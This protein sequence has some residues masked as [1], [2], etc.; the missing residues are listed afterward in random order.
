MRRACRSSSTVHALAAPERSAAHGSDRSRISFGRPV[1]AGTGIPTAVLAERF[2]AGDQPPDWRKTTVQA[3][4]RSGTRS[5]AKSTSRPLEPVT[6]FVDESLDSL[7]VVAALPRR[8][9]DRPT[10][11]RTF[12][13]VLRR[14]LARRS[15]PQRLGRP[16]AR[17]TYPLPPARQPR[18][19]SR[20]GAGHL[21]SRAE[22]HR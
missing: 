5:A 1:I 17:Q 13:R 21:C 2:K 19:A 11:H 15:R 12:P 6:F 22:C 9:G 10:S 3:K 8:R 16:D 18:P 4:K 14:S 7:S 20:K